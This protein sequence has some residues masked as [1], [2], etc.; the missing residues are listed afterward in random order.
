M[1]KKLLYLAT[2][3]IL[4]L[5][6][7]AELAHAQS[8]GEWTKQS[9]I[10]TGDTIEDIYFLNENTG[11]MVSSR[12]IW[13]TNDG[14]ENWTNQYNDGSPFSSVFFVN[15][16]VGWV[17]GSTDGTGEDGLIL[18]TNDGG[19]NWNVQTTVDSGS[20][21]K[22]FFVDSNTGW[23][24]GYN[25]AIL[26]TIDGGSTW[27][28]QSSGTTDRINDV[29]F[30]DSS[31][32]WAVGSSTNGTILKTTDGGDNWNTQ[33]SDEYSWIYGIHFIDENTGWTSGGQGEILHTTDG[34]TNWTL[35]NSGVS[36]LFEDIHFVDAN[37]GWALS[38]D[39][40]ILYTD[41]GGTNWTIQHEVNRDWMNSIFFTDANNGW[42]VGQ[43][44]EILHTKNGGVSWE[45]KLKG[46]PFS[47][48]GV[49]FVNSTT[50]WVVGQNGEIL[51]TTNTGESWVKE[52][53]GTTESL[54]DV[55][56]IDETIGW[57]VG[58]GDI[59]LKTEDMGETWNSQTSITSTNLNGVHFANNNTGWVVGY[60]GEIIYTND[61]GSIWVAQNSGVSVSLWGIDFIDENIGWSVGQLGTILYTEDG[62][63]T[64]I[65][66]SSGESGYLFS[67]DFVNE[68]E[69]WA[70]GQNGVILHTDDGGTTWNS[71]SSGTSRNLREVH[72]VSET[73]IWIVG[74]D[75]T[76]LTTND[77][78]V[79]WTVEDNVTAGLQSVV[80]VDA[81][82]GWA[83]GHDGGTGGGNI[84]QFKAPS[85]PFIS[86]LNPEDGNN[87]ISVNESV[88]IT[89]DKAV[90]KVNLSGVDIMDSD[91][92]SVGNITATLFDSTITITHDDFSYGEEYT[93]NISAGSVESTDGLS[94]EEIS[95]SFT[96]ILSAPAPAS[97]QPTDG[98]TGV[99]LNE[100]VSVIF[101]KAVNEVDLSGITIKDSGGDALSG[102]SGS[103][104]DSTI[105]ITHDDFINDEEYTVTIPAGAVEN[106]DGV[107]NESVSWT[108]T[109]ILNAPDLANFEPADGSTGVVLD[110][111]VSV[112]FDMSVTELDLSGVTL[113]DASGTSAGNVSA[114]L[115]DST[116]TISHDNF[117]K[118]EAYTAT[119][120]GGVVENADGVANEAVS[121]SFTAILEGPAVASRAPEGGATG[122]ALDATVSVSF[123]KPVNEIDLSGITIKDSGETELGG[124]SGSLTDSTV[125]ITHNNFIN[126]EEYTVSIPAG[127]VENADGLGNQ[128]ISWS[129]T[130]IVAKAEKVTLSDPKQD[131][132]AVKLDPEFIWQQADGANEYQLKISL[133]G[134]FNPDSLIADTTGLTNTAFTFN[135]NLEHNTTYWW[136]VR[137]INE[138]GTGAWSEAWSFTTVKP[139]PEQITLLTPEN[140]AEDV[141]LDVIFEWDNGEHAESYRI[142]LA[143]D[144]MFESIIVDSTIVETEFTPMEDLESD[145]GYF[146]RV[147]GEN[148]DKT[149]EWSD[150]FTFNTALATSNENLGNIPKEFTLGQNYPNPFNPTTQINYALPEAAEVRLEVF[151]MLG[152]KIM[153]LVDERKGAGRHQA[154]FD[155]GLLSSGMYIYRIRA[156]DF[157]QTR[158][159]MLIK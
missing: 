27:I 24:V 113:T 101:D 62:G 34:G 81:Y 37:T 21:F 30:I 2:Y 104:T 25:G 103:L 86:D 137:G 18:A 9:P 16:N 114:S 97:L 43:R 122:V 54:R 117:V 129:F 49:S 15:E 123:D 47:L 151:D 107:G 149:G 141:E 120:P 135:N 133:S 93:V 100:T 94:N 79:S 33:T 139:I 69:G 158:K 138:A 95:W 110:A 3:L 35:Q 64:W 5:N 126:G 52:E 1:I 67:V 124:V 142:Q 109:A 73:M 6:F 48:Y 60:N 8:D 66:Q 38:R 89:F 82:T 40:I 88:S 32:G 39:G 134:S 92:T 58:T 31:T 10:P 90:T 112:T 130:T 26:H 127:A 22:A 150:T 96:S 159:M 155:A 99:A 51:S 76:I 74:D 28:P 17:V 153:T 140:E 136:H 125:I 42:A 121:W 115:T 152:R 156:G 98:A 83:V 57:A 148:S 116:V 63:A 108:F 50:G 144:D 131:S 7:D 154:T 143:D 84:L 20:L 53:S 61:G 55:Y 128:F 85:P 70:S 118:G 105:T 77:G 146:W 72:A 29:H 75:G 19:A 45:S 41:D 132:T 119:I 68:S 56:F 87:G 65:S 36:S 23:V 4:L 91:G 12:D 11:W 13:F 46:S 145:A 147:R 78:G 157:L 14:G 102:V 71:Q 59:I 106:N 80:F 44:T 111:V